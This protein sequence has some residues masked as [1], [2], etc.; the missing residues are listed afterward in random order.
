MKRPSLLV[1]S[2]LLGFSFGVT[3]PAETVLV[4]E[5]FEK[6]TNT[7][8]VV[9]NVTSDGNAKWLSAGGGTG[10]SGALVLPAQAKYG[11]AGEPPL[12]ILAAS[13]QGVAYVTLGYDL[14]KVASLRVKIGTLKLMGTD[15]SFQFMIGARKI[16]AAVAY[17]YVFQRDSTGFHL[18]YKGAPND[19]L[20]PIGVTTFD[21]TIEGL[22]L[23]VKK[24]TQQLYLLGQPL[25]SEAR[26][27]QD[28]A[29]NGIPDHLDLVTIAGGESGKYADP[30]VMDLQIVAD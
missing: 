6:G 16:S 23:V 7:A 28:S 22:E 27:T 29:S 2:L 11:H 15:M 17:G 3:C 26:P 21:G 24:N 19:V 9:G 25:D 8:E 12:M 20:K 1:A 10:T 18:F 13:V 14:D 4:H 5:T 30:R